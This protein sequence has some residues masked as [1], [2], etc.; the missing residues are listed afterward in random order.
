MNFTT[1]NGLSI[2]AK[3]RLGFGLI[4]ALLIVVTIIGIAQVNAISRG[5]ITIGDVNS[6]KQRYAINF[7]GSVHDRAIALRD[8]VLVASDEELR[9]VLQRIASLSADYEK[10]AGPLDTIFS[11]SNAPSNDEKQILSS[12]KET[13][14]RTMPLIA[15]VILLRQSGDTDQAKQLLLNEAKPAFVEWLGRINKLID[16]EENLNHVESAAARASAN[17]FQT[18]M[19]SMC[20]GA[21]LVGTLVATFIARTITA[22]MGGEPREASAVAQNIAAGDLAAEIHK[23]ANDNSSVLAAMSE[24]RTSLVNIVSQ[25][26]STTDAIY[27]GS[28]EIAL[29]NQ[30]LSARTEQQALVLEK[31]AAAMTEL[32]ATVK[33][34]AGNA[35]EANQLAQSASDVAVKGG[36][37]VARVVD[38]MESINSSA[39]KIVDIIGVIDGIAF[40]T[41]ILALNAAVEAARAG[42]QGRGFA[43][44]ASEVR[45]LAQRSAAAAKEI[46]TLIGDS[47]EKCAMGSQLVSEAGSTME[48]IVG[49]VKKVTDI[50]GEIM[51][52][53]D[54]QSTGID[55]VHQAISQMDQ[56]TQQNAAMVEEAAGSA[57]SL[58]MLATTLSEHVAIFKLLPAGETSVRPAARHNPGHAKVAL[59]LR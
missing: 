15:K 25:V 21:L 54:E 59:R 43:V 41:N 16:Y 20:L 50:M 10:S 51:L 33:Q 39:K 2:Q 30:D 53:S 56:V 40:Q 3:L 57:A 49:S 12:I 1:T 42:D 7:R 4:L 23:A 8:V 47:V 35:R 32:T 5:L 48:E 46:K 34:N 24:M 45:N 58:Q 55:E 27:S 28:A 9:T 17:G 36:T 22:A 52:A 38:T 31:T 6:V 11:S 44:V 29:G 37:V 18:L 14:S 19:L 26:R 13:E